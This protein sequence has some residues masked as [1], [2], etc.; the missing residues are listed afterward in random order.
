MEI[1]FTGHDFDR[2]IS[3]STRWKDGVSEFSDQ[4]ENYTDQGQPYDK[5]V[6]PGWTYAYWIGE[7]YTAVVLA[8]SFLSSLNEGYEV[9]WDTSDEFYGWVIV[10]NYSSKECYG[11]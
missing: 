5:P 4:F 9:L 7:E 2:M 8:K 10:T 1:L 3:S 11:V 6:F